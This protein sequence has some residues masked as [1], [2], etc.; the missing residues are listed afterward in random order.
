L[1]NSKQ[2]KNLTTRYSWGAYILAETPYKSIPL[3]LIPQETVHNLISSQ[4]KIL[5]LLKKSTEPFIA[6]F[7][8]EKKA[9]EILNKKSTWFWQMRKSGKLKFRK[10]GQTTYYSIEDI[11]NLL[12]SK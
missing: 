1:Q 8:T 6:D 11:Q 9:M 2:I 5:Q 7:V 10:I 4:E 3:A 12:K